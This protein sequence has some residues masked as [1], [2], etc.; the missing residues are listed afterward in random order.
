MALCY[1][2]STEQCQELQSHVQLALSKTK[3]DIEKIVSKKEV[4]LRQSEMASMLVKSELG[5][6]NLLPFPSLKSTGNKNS[7]VVVVDVIMITFQGVLR[8]FNCCCLKFSYI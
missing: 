7:V 3:S 1:T 4:A 2:C 5:P 8:I 6:R